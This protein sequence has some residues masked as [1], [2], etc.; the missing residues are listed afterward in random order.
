M[1]ESEK[2][3]GLLNR[4]N[5]LEKE[6]RYLKEVLKKHNINI[7][8]N[9]LNRSDRNQTL[10]KA[11]LFYAY[12]WGRTDVY[13]KRSVNKI[14]G[15]VNYFPQCMNFWKDG[16]HRK[17][18]DAIK[19]HEC[20]KREY[21]PLK[22][23]DIIAHLKGYKEDGS[24]VI[25]VYPLLPNNT[26]RFLVFD[27]DNHEIGSNRNDFANNDDRYK[28]EI[29]II[30][31]ICLDNG[32]DPLVERSRSGK[33]AH[34]WLFFKEEIEASLVRKFAE[35]LL[36]SGAE[37][38]N[39]KSFDYYDRIFPAQDQ[40]KGNMIGSAI[41]LPLQGRALKNGNSAFVD[42]D[43]V[44]YPDQWSI[45]L[46]KKK[47]DKES[48]DNKLKTY[49]SSSMTLFDDAPWEMS[50]SFKKVDIE[51][52][53]H[54]TL[55]NGIYINKEDLK[56]RLQ[57]RIRELAAFSNPVFYK[58]QALNLY[59][60]SNHRY[61]Y[62]GE[63]VGEYIHIPRGLLETLKRKCNESGIGYEI[64]DLR[65]SGKT[66]DVEFKGHLKESQKPLIDVF[67]KYD[68]GII[69][70]AT[71]FG[72]TAICCFA[73][74]KF[75]K[76]TL[77]I[78]ENSNLIKQWQDE[79]N[80]FL[81]IHEDI[82]EYTTKSG[83]IRKRKDII[84][85]LKAGKDTLNGVI[86]IAMAGSLKN[87]NGFHEKLRDY[88]LVIIDECH[89]SASDTISEI[90]KEIKAKYI[91]GV[92][93]TPKRGDKLEK[94]SFMLIG[95]IIFKYT[96]KDR[97]L[98]QGIPHLVYPRFTST[99]IKKL[100]QKDLHPNEAYEAVREDKIRNLLIVND[101]KE[102][103]KN[104]RTPLI[105]TRFLEHVEEL[106][107]LLNGEADNVFVLSGKYS[108]KENDKT[109]TKLKSVSDDET[110]ILIGTGQYIG[111]GFNLPRLDTL[112]M[113]MPIADESLLEQYVGRLNRDY[114]NKK[115]VIVYDY[116][117]HHIAMFDKMYANKRLKAYKKIGFDIVTKVYNEKISCNTIFDYY[118]YKE[119]FSKDISNAN[120]E[121]IIASPLL[122]RQKV[123]DFISSV[124]SLMI[125]GI[126]VKII[127]L[128]A[129][130]IYYG[131]VFKWQMLH[132]TIINNGIELLLKDECYEK[133]CI[134]D[135]R[136]VW[137]GS[138]NLLGKDDIDDNL[139]RLDSETIAQE[140]LSKTFAT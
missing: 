93:A 53:I 75:K 82:P 84:G 90:L 134:I 112:I 104:K 83:K 46:S 133:Y 76:N 138:T 40:L 28:E 1:N 20:Q 33:G 118:S 3:Q 129:E 38:Y 18:K 91:Y 95:D 63:D 21:K 128:K 85:V 6:N 123:M 139:I 136:L 2:I 15:E 51:D 37:K 98:E 113:A 42:D 101:V 73:I 47:I 78:L 135:N 66:I 61:I 29:R 5:K 62:L 109:L 102:C 39:L 60:L 137:Y 22:K 111:E 121:I 8:N 125:A 50:D 110:M 87:K 127:T 12:F 32:L 140:L 71:S 44:P 68:N 52:R 13:A 19:C 59:N 70:A 45:L 64:T 114:P 105:L 79:I 17:N 92:S 58:N 74:S 89:H 119:A 4:I 23:E 54:I 7:N 96:A 34:L 132:D 65:N 116:I 131:D 43:W 107:C 117:D 11:T 10:D 16:C 120:K 9:S 81:V 80:K 36:K 97:A 115:D 72:K 94:I 49:N 108:K 55:S 31:D 41:A 24:D 27:F 86:D 122:N 106:A 69:Q 48:I 124:Q 100:S 77:I 30:K 126:K 35:Y 57:N 26:C 56:P 25:A 14:S 67:D 99:I 103:I 130:S 88:G